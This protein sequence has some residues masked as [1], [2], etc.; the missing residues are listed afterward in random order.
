MFDRNTPGSFR[1]ICSLQ[2]IC[3][4]NGLA[5]E[6]GCRV[7][8]K[9]PLKLRCFLSQDYSKKVGHVALIRKAMAPVMRFSDDQFEQS[10]LKVC[11]KVVP[12]SNC[13]IS[14]IELRGYEL[15]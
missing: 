9:Q 15:K 13:H 12:S 4:L 7:S 10:L 2:P 6:Y 1:V 8:R 11:I 14:S 5:I 3:G